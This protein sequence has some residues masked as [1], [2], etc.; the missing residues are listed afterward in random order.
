M[1]IHFFPNIWADTILL[2]KDGHFGLIDACINMDELNAYFLK[3]GVKKLDFIILTHFHRD[4][5]GSLDEVIRTYPV[6]Q[7]IFKDYSGVDAWADNGL[8]ADDEYRTNEM[9]IC[10]ELKDTIKK[11]SKLVMSNEVDELLWMGI[12]LKLFYTENTMKYV[13]EDENCSAYHKH[14]FSENHNNMPIF[15]EYA[16]RNVL[17][18]GDISDVKSKDERFSFM[19]RRLANKLNCKLDIYKAAHHGLVIGTPE[20]LEIYKPNY[21]VIT[22]DEINSADAVKRLIAANPAV[23][24]FIM[25]N[26]GKVFEIF[27][28]G[29][30]VIT[31]LE[32]FKP[33]NPLMN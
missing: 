3:T 1:K 16:G 9:R 8:T 17:L 12:P 23:N 2:E 18:S 29:E 4:H 7:V 25:S 6:E 22:N 28:N 5:Y 33:S 10:N 20:T 31:D 21:A 26:G 14:C 13:F 27:P 19:N 32:G 11:Y 15:F 24:V 30:I